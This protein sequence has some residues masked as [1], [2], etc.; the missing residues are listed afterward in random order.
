MKKQRTKNHIFKRNGRWH[1]VMYAW[2]KRDNGTYTGTHGF[3]D[4]K[5]LIKWL[6]E[7]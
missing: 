1:A 4:I 7:S 6:K 3:R 2:G 5:D